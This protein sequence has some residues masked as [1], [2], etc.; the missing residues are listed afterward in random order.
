MILSIVAGGRRYA[1]VNALRHDG[2]TP[3]LLG[4]SKICS[5]DSARRALETLNR[6]K[7]DAWRK[8]HLTF[9]LHPVMQEDWILDTDTMVKPIYGKQ[10]GAVVGYNPRKPG[11]PYHCYH[12]YM[13]ANLR[14]VVGVNVTPGNEHSSSEGLLGLLDI[15]D[16][17]PPELQ[18]LPLSAGGS[19]PAFLFSRPARRSL[20]FRPAWSLSC[21]CSPST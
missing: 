15:L 20:A 17:L 12:S 4:L 13:I 11:R 10:E 5:D 9:P 3:A 16:S 1:H 21:S 6:T 2:I 8:H 7:A 14:L 18:G 19:A